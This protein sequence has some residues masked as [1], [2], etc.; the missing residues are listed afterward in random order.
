MHKMASKVTLT[1][2]III[3]MKTILIITAIA[4]ATIQ[5]LF[6]KIIHNRYNNKVKAAVV[7]TYTNMFSNI[8]T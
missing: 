5:L 6:I 2:M 8:R 3:T 1:I 4:I 7:L